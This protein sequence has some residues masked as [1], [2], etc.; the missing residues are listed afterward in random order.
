M[1]CLF[2]YFFKEPVSGTGDKVLDKSLGQMKSLPH[3]VSVYPAGGHPVDTQMVRNKSCVANW[4]SVPG[5]EAQDSCF[6]SGR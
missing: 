4:D 1:F 2:G 5:P 3:T 6:S